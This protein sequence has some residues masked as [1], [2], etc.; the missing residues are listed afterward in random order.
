MERLNE[1]VYSLFTDWLSVIIIV[2]AVYIGYL[3]WSPIHQRAKTVVI[4]KRLWKKSG[5]YAASA[6]KQVRQVLSGRFYRLR[7]ESEDF[8]LESKPDLALGFTQ[9][10]Q[11]FSKI[12]E[13]CE[14][15]KANVYLKGGHSIEI[16]WEDSDAYIKANPDKVECR[17]ISTRRPRI[18]D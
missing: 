8:G 7:S 9:S 2:L 11:S 16:N 4:S 3:L 10:T 14:P 1:G 5:I 12:S 18:K 6:T 13:L 15:I 17:R